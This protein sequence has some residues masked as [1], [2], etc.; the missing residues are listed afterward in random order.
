MADLFKVDFIQGKTDAVDYGQVK[1][2][3]V[4]SATKRMII[5][6]AMSADKL[7]SVSN[8][9]REPRRCTFECFPS[10]W[11][12]DYI[13]AGTYE[14]ER[15]I[16][17]YEV[18]IYRNG[19]LFFSGII[20]TTQMSLD[21]GTGVLKFTCYDKLKLLAL[22]SDITH[23]YSLSAGYAP[24]WILG[25]SIQDIMQEIPVAIASQG[26]VVI[27]DTT[28]PSGAPITLVQ[29]DYDDMLAPSAV[30]GGWTYEVH[31]STW[32]SPIRGWKLRPEANCADYLF[33]HFAVIH[34]SSGTDHIYQARARGRIIRYYHHLAGVT[35]EHEYVGGWDESTDA[36][37]GAENDLRDY[38][39]KA[40]YDDT[41]LAALVGSGSVDGANYGSSHAAG[42]FA[43]ATMHGAVYPSRLHPGMSYETA[44]TEQTENLKALQAMLMLY[45]ATLVCNAQGVIQIVPKGTWSVSTRT[46]SNNDVIAMTRTRLNAEKPDLSTLDVL[47]GDTAKLAEYVGQDLVGFHAGVIQASM[48]IDRIDANPIQLLDRILVDGETWGVTEIECDFIND[49]M[50]VKAWLL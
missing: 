11:I 39:H 12:E 30:G 16:S 21:A 3:L 33:A 10:T 6:L 42:L 4:D 49:E 44:Q 1:H 32:S 15:Y 22:Y 18:K 46:I 20:D 50:K 47:A 43:T 24:E 23:Y 36:I 38:F 7:T 26:N 2:S 5:T 29:I 28:I 25:Y 31:T 37:E 45:N 17:H 9:T 35:Q 27:P 34:G 48:T 8:Y 19:V 13:L 14:H 41:M 40:G